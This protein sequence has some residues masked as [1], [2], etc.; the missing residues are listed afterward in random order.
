VPRTPPGSTGAKTHSLG[1]VR[2]LELDDRSVSV[3]LPVTA[4]HAAALQAIAREDAAAVP[5]S[6]LQFRSAHA[7]LDGL[8]VT[9]RGAEGGY[10]YEVYLNLPASGDYV[11][12]KDRYLLGTLGPFEVE[13]GRH[14][15]NHSTLYYPLDDQLA[16]YSAQQLS[17]L[18]VSFVRV[19]GENPPRGR[20][21]DVAE[22]RIELSTESE[23]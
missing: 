3:S 2:A 7:V 21:I 20:V 5:D 13:A 16:N 18:T 1:G 14:H 12:P 15:G 17:Q 10:F 4:A 8:Q 23:R 19:D 11:S 22:V 9:P 6:T